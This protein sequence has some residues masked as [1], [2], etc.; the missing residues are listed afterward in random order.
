M[1]QGSDSKLLIEWCLIDYI[2]VNECYGCFYSQFIFWLGVNLQIIVIV[3][4][5]FVV[6]FG[7]DVFWLLVGLFIGQFF[8]GVVMVLYVV[9]GLCLGLLQMIFSWVQFGVYGVCILIVLV[10]LMYLGFIVI[11]M[12]FFG[13]VIGQF[14]GFSDSVG[15]FI[16]VVFFVLVMVF[17]YCVIYI[18]GWIVSV[19]GIIVFVYLFSCLMLFSDIGDLFVICYFSWVLFFFVVLLVVFWQIVF[20]F[21]VV[22]YLCYLLVFILLW[23]IFFVVGFG[24]VFG[25][26][27]SMVFGVFFVVLVNGQFVGCEV[28][29]IV[30]LGS[31]GIVVVLFY[32]SIVFGKVIIFMLN[33][34]GS[35]MCIVII[36]SSVCG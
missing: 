23:K 34:Y 3:I 28:V 1:I 35:F 31:S 26:Q 10:C 14:I 13:Q 21:Y 33:F 30:G 12:V 6:V 36:I 9:Q 32:F 24:L 19:F 4:G 7:G 16:F 18:I 5:V 15:I 17:G 20:G 8:G 25:V 22:D 27:V 2:L 29:Y 11:G